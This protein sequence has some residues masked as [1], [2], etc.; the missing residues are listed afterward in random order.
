MAHLVRGNICWIVWLSNISGHTRVALGRGSVTS[1]SCEAMAGAWVLM[2]LFCVIHAGLGTVD[3]AAV[4]ALELP[5]SGEAVGVVAGMVPRPSDGA[6]SDVVPVT[7]TAEREAQKFSMGVTLPTVPVRLVKRILSGEYV[8]MGELSQEALRAEFRRAVDGENQKP[9][10]SR[11]IR[12]VVDRDA[13]AA[14]F[15]QY[16]GT[17]CRSHP[18]KA[19]ALWGHLAI[20]MSCQNISTSGWWRTYDESLRHSY[21][22]MEDASFELNQC[23]FTQAMVENSEA[24]QRAPTPVPLPVAQARPRK[25]RVA[26]FAWNDGRPCTSTPCRFAHCCVR[27]GGDHTRRYCPLMSDAPLGEEGRRG[28]T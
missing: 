24:S 7:K 3:E 19:V 14:S 10:K 9:S 15:A 17:V 20:V 2:A 5:R 1:K 23:L 13:W 11:A 18:E 6:A 12:P 27:C 8:D 26:C 22:S 4:A 21:S 25:R 16:A 28:S